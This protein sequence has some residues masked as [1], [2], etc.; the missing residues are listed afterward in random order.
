MKRYITHTT[1]QFDVDENTIYITMYLYPLIYADIAI[2]CNVSYNPNDKKYHTDTPHRVL[3]GPLSGPG[4]E[5]E[6][7]ISDEWEGFVE[8]CK[9]L[10]KELGFSIIHT[11]RSD[12]SEKSE[13]VIIYGIDNTPC[14]SIVYDLR[15]SDHPFDAKF[16]EDLKDLALDYLKMNNILDGTATKNG[17]DFQV[18]KVTV[19]SVKNDSWDKAF[20]R[21]YLKLK[22]MRRK[23]RVRLNDHG[24]TDA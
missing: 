23:V 2:Y 4:E 17:I 11:E 14:G 1:E 13:Y 12:N 18:E 16:P 21:L 7:P 24:D 5:L 8:D 3:N 6:P 19:G 9:W 15:L 10:V 22:T 20:N